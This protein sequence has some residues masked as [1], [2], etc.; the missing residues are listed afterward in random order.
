MGLIY[1]R[2]MRNSGRVNGSLVATRMG[3]RSGD[4]ERHE[5]DGQWDAALKHAIT[6][7]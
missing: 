3:A 6:A 2:K 4:F 1:C 7:T 5:S